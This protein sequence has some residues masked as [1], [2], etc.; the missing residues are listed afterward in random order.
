MHPRWLSL[1]ALISLNGCVF[2]FGPN[3]ATRGEVS[4]ANYPTIGVVAKTE[5]AHVPVSDERRFNLRARA[6]LSV[7]AVL[8]ERG[9]AVREVDDSLRKKVEAVLSRNIDRITKDEMTTIGEQL[10]IDAI[11]SIRIA[12]FKLS[13]VATEGEPVYRTTARVQM[14]LA[15]VRTGDVIWNAAY[16]DDLEHDE[17]FPQVPVLLDVTETIMN[18]FPPRPWWAMFYP[19]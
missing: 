8:M 9:Y 2:F 15:D 6:E 18:A 4:P 7:V 5:P 11:L 14:S 1:A 3:V 17:G 19:W 10:S 16:D 12:E 13:K